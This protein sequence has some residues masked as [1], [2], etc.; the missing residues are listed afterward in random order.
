MHCIENYNIIGKKVI[1]WC[2]HKF[3][4]GKPLKL[5]LSNDK[6]CK[7]KFGQYSCGEINIFLVNVVSIDLLIQTIIHEYIHHLQFPTL[8]GM[9]LYYKILEETGYE[10]HPMEEEANYLAK[11]Y[12]EECKHDLGI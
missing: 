3:G 5:I 12:W 6:R 8:K 4:K 9:T 7:R 11:I 2:V 10:H 1:K